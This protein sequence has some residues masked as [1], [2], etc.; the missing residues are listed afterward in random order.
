MNN[1]NVIMPVIGFL[2]VGGQYKSIL[3]LLDAQHATLHLVTEFELDPVEFGDASTLS[4][5][6]VQLIRLYKYLKHEL[7]DRISCAIEETHKNITIKRHV[8]TGPLVQEVTK[9]SASLEFSFLL[10]D[11]SNLGESII[12]YL[13]QDISLKVCRVEKDSGVNLETLAEL[14]AFSECEQLAGVHYQNVNLE[15]ARSARHSIG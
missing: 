14:D 13:E 4:N 7:L 2:K 6:Q 5:H 10:A 15:S 9:L 8:V 1:I 11:E 12:A 3:D